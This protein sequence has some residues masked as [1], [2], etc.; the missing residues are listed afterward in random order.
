MLQVHASACVPP[1]WRSPTKADIPVGIAGDDP[2]AV[3]ARA[4]SVSVPE[5]SYYTVHS[6]ETSEWQRAA[7]SPPIERGPGSGQSKPN[8]LHT[9]TSSSASLESVD[10]PVT[11]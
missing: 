2:R 9:R 7:W 4:A 10:I 8:G 1:K 3:L 6:G 5:S 11:G